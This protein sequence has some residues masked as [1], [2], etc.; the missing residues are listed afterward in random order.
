MR[1]T[2][3]AGTFRCTS[4]APRRTAYA[5]SASSR[6]RGRSAWFMGTSSAP[7]PV[8]MSKRNRMV[9]NVPGVRVFPSEANLILFRIGKAGDGR[10]GAAWKAMAARGV[11]VRNFDRPGPLSGCLRVTPG[12]PDENDLFL[13]ELR[14]A[15]GA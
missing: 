4:L 11:L 14:L 10:A 3:F 6:V 12:T 5:S 2:G 1:S 7:H 9:A 15:L 8:V 13:A